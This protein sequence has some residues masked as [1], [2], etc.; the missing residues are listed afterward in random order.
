MDQLPFWRTLGWRKLVPTPNAPSNPWLY[1]AG[2]IVLAV[3]VAIA[4]FRM[5]TPKDLPLEELFKN[6]T[7]AFLLM[8]MA[9]L[10]PPFVEETLFLVYF[11][12]LFLKRLFVPPPPAV[13]RLL[14]R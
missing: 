5:H 9:V 12:P 7:G 6:R 13:T 3:C 1:F 14:F 8:G 2:G 10:L 11:F 4:R